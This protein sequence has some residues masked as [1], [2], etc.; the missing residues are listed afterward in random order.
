MRDL[1]RH[2]PPLGAG[3]L[4]EVGIIIP[5]SGVWCIGFWYCRTAVSAVKVAGGYLIS[6]GC[7]GNHGASPNQ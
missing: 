2:I 6:A 5:V 7:A 1:G 4:V 3:L